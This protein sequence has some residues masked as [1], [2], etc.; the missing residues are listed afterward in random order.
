[1]IT[2]V[3]FASIGWQTYIIFAVINAASVPIIYFCYP[4]TACR[5]LE[6]MDV[7][8]AKSSG[9][10]NTVKI[11]KSEPRHYG[12]HGEVL[13]DLLPDTC[14]QGMGEMK[15]SAYVEMLEKKT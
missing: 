4:E 11:A 2:P 13:R 7:I 8:F 12:R 5:S 15:E 1:M 6:E 14:G 3:S 9:V 10:Y